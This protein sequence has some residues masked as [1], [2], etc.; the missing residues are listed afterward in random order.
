[1][2]HQNLIIDAEKKLQTIYQNL[3]KIVEEN[4]KKVINA[5]KENNV[6]EACFNMTTGYG[7]NDLGRDTIE[8]VYATIF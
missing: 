2:N 6:S 8:K 5:F 7:Y 4:S 3:D 1:M